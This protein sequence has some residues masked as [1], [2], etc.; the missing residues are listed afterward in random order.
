M[1]CTK[2]KNLNNKKKLNYSQIE[3]AFTATSMRFQIHSVSNT[4]KYIECIYETNVFIVFA[5]KKTTSPVR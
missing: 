5:P 4:F 1:I 3:N 2:S